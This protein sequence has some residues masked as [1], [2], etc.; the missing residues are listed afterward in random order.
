MQLCLNTSTIKPVPI[1]DKIRLAGE[2]GFDAIEPWIVEVYEHVGR[3]GEVRDIEKALS[4]HGLTV[5]CMVA[6]RQ[7][8]EVDDWEYQR[9]R[10][11]AKRRMEL[12][13]RLGA[14]HIIATPPRLPCDRQ[15]VLE[16]YVD[17]LRVGREVGVMP[18]MEY[19]SIFQS[20]RTLNEAWWI[21]QQASPEAGATLVVDAFHTWNSGGTL[22]DLQQVD[23]SRI[24]HYH[25]DD[26]PPAPGRPAG[27]QTDA[28]RVLPGD[29]VID[30]KSELRLL[31][32]GGYTGAISL[33]LFNAELWAKDPNDVL[34]RGIE[35]MRELLAG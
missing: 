18:A 3:G 31:R 35:R 32:D 21:V 6:L 28:D 15:R 9:Q 7:W 4:D 10:D 1:L 11:E 29:G 22:A 19:I 12:A 25:I 33:E 13:A 24:P 17:L 23:I 26:A 30:L 34:R 16:R 2:H 5:P 8:A 20:V 27:Q 14:K